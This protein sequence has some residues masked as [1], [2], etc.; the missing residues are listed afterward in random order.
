MQQIADKP[1]LDLVNFY[2]HTPHGVQLTS[3]FCFSFFFYFYSHTPHGVQLNLTQQKKFLFLFLL[4]HPSRGATKP[5]TAEKIPLSISTHTPLTG[6]NDMNFNN[7][8]SAVFLL[9]HP[10]R[11]ATGL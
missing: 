6:C 5:Y 11:G 7:L 4:T 2:S 3:K 9:T 8:D 1:T 10:S